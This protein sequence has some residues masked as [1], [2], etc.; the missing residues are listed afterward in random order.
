MADDASREETDA[1]EYDELDDPTS[2]G[3]Q[4]EDQDIS[5]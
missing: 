5:E 2:L 4:Q 3:M 1:Q